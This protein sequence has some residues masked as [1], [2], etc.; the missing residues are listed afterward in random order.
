MQ[1]FDNLRLKP[2]LL[3]SFGLIITL[4]AALG[5][6]S[7]YQLASVN[8]KSTEIAENWL[9]SVE[10]VSALWAETAE[11]RALQFRHIT[12]TTDAGMSA[13][14][15]LMEAKRAE[16]TKTHDA[17]VQLISSPE[18]KALADEFARRW[19]AYL[20]NWEPIRV[21][22]RANR[23]E[24]ATL[25]MQGEGQKRYD[26][27]NATLKQLVQLNHDGGVSASAAGDREYALARTLIL[28]MLALTAVSGLAI[29]W[30]A[31]T[32]MSTV[33]N[34]VSSVAQEIAVGRLDHEV[35]VRSKDEVG[36]VASALNRIVGAQ[37]QLSA[38]A[39]RLAAGDTTATITLRSEG[40]DL[41][42]S[43]TVLRD[44]LT[45]LTAEMHTLSTA[46]LEGRLSARGNAQAFHGT[47]HELIAGMNRTLDAIAAP[48]TEIGVVMRRVAD[49]DL[50]E[51]V[52]TTYPGAF[53][54]LADATNAAVEHLDVALNQVHAAAEQVAAAGTEIT[55]AAQSLAS[56]A[57]EQAASLEEVSASVHMFTSM[58]QQS[59]TNANEA[60]S[61]AASAQQDTT[62]GTARM[63]R[64]TQ[65]VE[66]IKKSS[67]DTAKII[68]TIDEIAFQT[69]LLALN[70]AVEAARA[71][72][73]GR[74]F[75][76]VAEEVRALA[77]R[78]AEAARNTTALIEQGQVSADRGVAL[79]GEVLL[80]FARISD[81][82]EKVAVV[83]AEI[84]AATEQQVD[85]VVQIKSAVDQINTVT[86]Q[87]AAN[88]EESASAATELESQ[89]QTLRE[90]VSE[91]TLTNAR[92]V[93]ASR[94]TGVGAGRP[95]LSRPRPVAPRR[96]TSAR[97]ATTAAGAP[98]SAAAIIPFDDDDSHA[99]SAF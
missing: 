67:A 95:K 64:L 60:R 43:F 79:N 76:V 55:S 23:N 98:R 68:K 33:L 12:S 31:A 94:P 97:L 57:S 70:A 16:F 8:D 13:A 45:S 84:S 65:A 99:L 53:A 44:T 4:G 41:S 2:K 52:S 15:S 39:Q 30:M 59:A 46:A 26:A 61:L 81:R 21:L 24:E 82:I 51:R 78:A 77:L 69:N 9:P 38:T 32:R 11:F 17:Y 74:G 87:V 89:A 73:A 56:G 90:T 1:W 80:S 34:D 50:R 37:R 72:D 14:E 18:E 7:I 83:T 42:R 92:P 49:R 71:G 20:A 22:S 93:Q 35:Q 3:L 40:D 88:A 6:F 25:A 86:Q 54:D 75:A 96:D 62:E 85:G 5:G 10:T 28:V 66:E 36:Q 58:T 48:L 91:F 27:M 63:E 19:D 47:Y 29:A